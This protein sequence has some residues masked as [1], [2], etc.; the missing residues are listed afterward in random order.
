MEN[1]EFDPTGLPSVEDMISQI[2][3]DSDKKQELQESQAASVAADNKAAEIA[4]DPRNNDQW[5]IKGLAKEGQSILSGGL[6]DTASS[7]ATF[8]ERT[9]DA[10]SG[11]MQREKEE[12]GYYEPEWTPFTD[13]DDPIITKTW[14]G[15]LLRGT[16]HFGSLAAGTVLAAK[17]LAATGIPLLAGGAAKL[18]GLGTLTRGAAIG[19]ISD[20]ISKESDG[21]N[22]LG[23]MRARYGWMD[24]PLATKET[25]HPIMMKFKNVVE[26]MGIGLVFEGDIHLLGK[27]S[28][29]VRKQIINR[30]ASIE[31]QSTTAALAQ[32]RKGEAEFRA[33]KNSP[34]AERHQGA[35]ISEVPAGD[36]YE[37][38]RRT[39]T[40]WG[41]EDGSTG[42]VTT[43]IERERIALEGGT[44]DEVVERTL[45]SL[46][47]D[48]KFS[49]ELES[50]KGNRKLLAAVWRDAI[51]EYHKITDGRSAMDMTPEEYLTD[52]FEKQKASIP[53]GDELFE[54]W[55][56]ETVL[57][58]DLVV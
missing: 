46:M 14:W 2:E 10:F 49:R 39:R 22:A 26:G 13:E 12:K 21:H 20:I 35:D 50:V 37:Q 16:V 56:A 30:N 7:L 27:G 19:G 28:S 36:A 9:M 51:T 3:E 23:A 8:P 57:T 18:L 1:V 45:R 33:A 52:L 17:G 48:D 53:L 5:G 25:D 4:V 43:A 47:S 44:T 29:T 55:S 11:E 41:S 58:A 40:D 31:N 24:T 38:L 54:T 6:Q 34:L 15:K 32:L 42:S